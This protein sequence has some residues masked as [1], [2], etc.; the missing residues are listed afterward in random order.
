MTSQQFAVLAVLRGLFLLMTFLFSSFT[1]AW[2]AEPA[3]PHPLTLN[4]VLM[5]AGHQNEQIR[6]AGEQLYRAE[7][8]P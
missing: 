4:D 5:S 6:I 8:L 1:T 7:R 3:A 2:S